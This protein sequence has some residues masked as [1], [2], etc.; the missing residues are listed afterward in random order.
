MANPGNLA[1]VLPIREF[2]SKV[3]RGMTVDVD[4]AN[5]SPCKQKKELWD[6]VHEV[7]HFLEQIGINDQVI[8][9]ELTVLASRC[10]CGP[11]NK[12]CLV[13]AKKAWQHWV[14]KAVLKQGNDL[15]KDVAKVTKTADKMAATV[16]KTAATVD[17]SAATLERVEAKVGKFFR[18]S[19][20]RVEAIADKTAELRAECA[21]KD[22]ELATLRESHVRTQQAKRKSHNRHKSEKKE[23]EEKMQKLRA[24]HTTR[25]ERQSPIDE[26]SESESESESENESESESESESARESYSESDGE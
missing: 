20:E 5:A 24:L 8:N 11:E 22:A 2:I 10:I 1:A 14:S 15:R 9:K 26:E 21:K 19:L 25:P 18:D 13:K 6:F 23:L 16:D 4:R 3:N 7:S 17:K 12:D